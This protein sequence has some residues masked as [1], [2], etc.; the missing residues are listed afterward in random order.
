MF[1]VMLHGCVFC[2]LLC[3][4]CVIA[5][6]RSYTKQSHK[7]TQ[8]IHNKLHKAFTLSYKKKNST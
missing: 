2:D 3:V 5:I 7:V 8:S 1:D 6:S 4:F